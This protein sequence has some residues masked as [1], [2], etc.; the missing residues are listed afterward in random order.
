MRKTTIIFILI[1]QIVL[2]FFFENIHSFLN[3][4]E[5]KESIQNGE[6]IITHAKY[7]ILKYEA[8][9]KKI[10]RSENFTSVKIVKDFR[11]EPEIKKIGENPFII[12]DLKSQNGLI[13]RFQKKLESPFSDSISKLK[14]FMSAFIVLFGIFT[15]ITG[16]YLVVLFKRKREVIEPSQM[17]LLQNYLSKLKESES[18]LKEIIDE[19]KVSVI[20]SEEVN[21]KI[22]NRINAAIVL[23]NENNR[24]EL[25]NP[26]AEKIFGKSAIFAKNNV[27]GEV[28]KGFPE[29]V[30]FI[31]ENGDDGTS[32]NVE[33]GDILFL[34]ELLPIKSFGNLI[35]IRDITKE[36]RREDI[37]NSRKNFMMLGEMTAF[38]T[39]EIRNSLGVIYGYSKTLKSEPEKTKKINNEIVFLTNMMENFLNFSKPLNL[40]KVSEVDLSLLVKLI[41]K[42][43]KIDLTV[44]KKT[45]KLFQ[46]DPNLLRSVFSNLTLNAKESGA[47][48]ITVNILDKEK[49][50]IA[51]EFIDN[52]SGIDDE[53]KDKIWY[54][55]YT[56]KPKGTGMGL[57]IVK[58]IVNFLNGEITLIKSDTEGTIFLITFYLADKNIEI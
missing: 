4:L 44:N 20:K 7:A 50:T 16:I 23:V 58:K 42:E 46:S 48:S 56:S 22:I 37:I 27:I 10:Q 26:S 3:V 57:S 12:F 25:F 15:L 41:C 13:F 52:G 43:N 33:S 28:F 34:V 39:H 32:G 17:P 30:R 47:D 11:K 35:I 14:G 53:K 40:S 9:P 36:K 49:N 18:V 1:I 24:I 55:F 2:L 21:K 38:L 19:Q 31:E 29:I 45:E 6:R 54:P 8:N 51:I 5:S